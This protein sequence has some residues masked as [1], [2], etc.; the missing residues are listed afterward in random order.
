MTAQLSVAVT[1]QK[2]ILVLSKQKEIRFRDIGELLWC[3][4]TFAKVRALGH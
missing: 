2:E 4:E 3:S 1:Y